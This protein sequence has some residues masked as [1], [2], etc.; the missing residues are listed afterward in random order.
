MLKI[1]TPLIVNVRFTEGNIH[2][3]TAVVA[4]HLLVDFKVITIAPNNY[5]FNGAQ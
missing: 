1:N 2:I 4:Q 3:Y 5:G